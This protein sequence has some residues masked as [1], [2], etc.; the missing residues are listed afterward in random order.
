M[1]VQTNSKIFGEGHG[2]VC[3]VLNLEEKKN[4][5]VSDRR[6]SLEKKINYW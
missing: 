4:M 5:F 2:M 3:A 1:P 6:M